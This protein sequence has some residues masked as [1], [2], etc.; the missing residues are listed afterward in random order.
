MEI[1]NN[2]EICYSG[3]EYYD[4][5][6]V[7]MYGKIWFLSVCVFLGLFCINYACLTSWLNFHNFFNHQYWGEGGNYLRENFHHFPFD[8]H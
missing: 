2:Y 7:I 1:F 4:V 3:V 5:E 8:S 6:F